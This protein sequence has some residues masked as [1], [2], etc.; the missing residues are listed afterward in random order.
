MKTFARDF[1]LDFE[2]DAPDYAWLLYQMA[3]A[4][5]PEQWIREVD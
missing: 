2:K 5:L 1:G 4:A 3:A